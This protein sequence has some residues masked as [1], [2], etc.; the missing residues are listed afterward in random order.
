[1]ACGVG[2]ILAP[3]F[4]CFTDQ[5]E[6]DKVKVARILGKTACMAFD[7]LLQKIEKKCLEIFGASKNCYC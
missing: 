1:M 2:K 4:F 7:F 5:R 6:N 3:S